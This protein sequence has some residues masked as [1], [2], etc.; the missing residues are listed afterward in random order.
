MRKEAL[1][2][3]SVRLYTKQ[4]VSVGTNFYLKLLYSGQS[5]GTCRISF[6][7]K[8]KDLMYHLDFRVNYSNVIN[9]NKLIQTMQKDG[10]W[11][12]RLRSS[13]SMSLAEGE[14]DVAVKVGPGYF[15]VWLNGVKYKESVVAD[16]ARLSRYTNLQIDQSGTCVSFDEKQSYTYT[17]D[18]SGKY[19][20]SYL[21]L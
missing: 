18:S 11:E 15:K 3:N 4:K 16:P 7:I 21:T 20:D 9:Y 17:M 8:E 13:E 10:G 14:N 1:S 12:D 6:N 19:R 2:G 5:T